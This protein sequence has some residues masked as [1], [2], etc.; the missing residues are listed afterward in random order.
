MPTKQNISK[1]RFIINPISG[2]GKNKNIP[3]LIGKILDRTKFSH[4]IYFT[5]SQADATRLSREAKDRG[6]DLVIAVGGDGTVHEVGKALIGSNTALGIIPTGSGNGLARHCGIPCDPVKAIK[7]INEMKTST[8]DTVKINGD[9]FLNMA[10]IG[11]D[12]Y[13]AKKF[14]IDIKRGFF[15][16]VKLVMRHFFSYKC[17]DYKLIIDGKNI[18]KKAFLISF[19]NS[20]QYGN[21]ICISP[22]AKIDDGLLDIAIL[23]P[24]PLVSTPMML[25]QLLSSKFDSSKY[26]DIIPAKDVTV[27]GGPFHT[28]LDGEPVTSKDS[29]HLSVLPSSLK[30]V[31]NL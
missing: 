1:V 28:H 18:E 23:R 14:S 25:L 11:F 27:E 7:L 15:T 3:L 22:K 29:L 24:F 21:N 31:C 16:Y 26:L 20:S 8:I 2:R 12:A 9:H 4:E 30:L 5:Q 10:G 19:A 17:Q 6:M 13:I